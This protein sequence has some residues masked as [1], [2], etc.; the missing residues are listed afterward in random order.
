MGGYTKNGGGGCAKNGYDSYTK[1]GPD[2][3]NRKM[4]EEFTEVRNGIQNNVR[5]VRSS[6]KPDGNVNIASNKASGYRFEILNE[7]EE[8]EV[9]M[10]EENQQPHQNP[11]STELKAKGVL[12]EI[13]NAYGSQSMSPDEFSREPS[14]FALEGDEDEQPT[15]PISE[16]YTAITPNNQH[17]PLHDQRCHH[18]PTSTVAFRTRFVLVHRSM[19]FAPDMCPFVD[20]L[21]ETHDQVK[22]DLGL[23]VSPPPINFLVTARAAVVQGVRGNLNDV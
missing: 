1:S 21:L 7:E 16:I 6:K 22:I 2:S 4:D 18:V 17:T 13:T 20:R 10:T 19:L 5:N 3:S 12:A 23:V 11:A 9:D 8:V 14:D 15:E